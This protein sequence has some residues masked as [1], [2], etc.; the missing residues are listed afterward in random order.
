MS[1]HNL[2]IHPCKASLVGL[3]VFC[4]ISCQ[5]IYWCYFFYYRY[6]KQR[7][8]QTKIKIKVWCKN[9][10]RLKKLDV[11]AKSSSLIFD[12]FLNALVI[13]FLEELIILI[14]NCLLKV[15]NSV[16]SPCHCVG[17]EQLTLLWLYFI[18][19]FEKCHKAVI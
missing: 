14:F 6:Y 18:S 10:L 16:K 7:C 5:P 12:S 19:I 2:Y 4:F 15:I 8:I 17:I 11:Y 9:I 1:F 13:R 3:V